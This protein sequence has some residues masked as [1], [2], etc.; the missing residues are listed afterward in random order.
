MGSMH[1]GLTNT[2]LMHPYGLTGP[3]LGLY[4]AAL[5]PLLYAFFGTAKHLS[6]GPIS[7]A[8]I[9]IPV[10]LKHL[11]FD[12]KDNSEAVKAERAEAAAALTFA[13]FA[14]F[15]AMS[16]L[17]MGMLI[18]F[19]SH[20]VMT[21]FVTATGIY[22]MINQLKYVSPVEGNRWIVVMPPAFPSSSTPI[23]KSGTCVTCRHILALRMPSDLEY[24]YQKIAWIIT[25]FAHARGASTALGFASLAVLVGVKIIKRIYPATVGD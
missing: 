10:A 20:A 2:T 1:N 5:G 12:A 19:L 22:V 4:S 16:F 14:V 23:F 8:S 17:R 18:R 11:G 24:N 6:V 9:F 13:V 21:G 25:N 3:M 15:L 7:L